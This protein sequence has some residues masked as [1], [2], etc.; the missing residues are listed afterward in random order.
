MSI[1][2]LPVDVL[3][4][5]FGSV[6]DLLLVSGQHMRQQCA[7]PELLESSFASRLAKP[8]YDSLKGKVVIQLHH[9]G[10]LLR[11]SVLCIL[12]LILIPP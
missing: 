5:H 3:F 11:G 10:I 2:V 6:T 1:L 8:L 9:H 4:K 12:I 7:V